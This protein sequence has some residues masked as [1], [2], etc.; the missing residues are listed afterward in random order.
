MAV[1][2][3]A[4]LSGMT[5]CTSD[6]NGQA[7]AGREQAAPGAPTWTSSADSGDSAA[8]AVE[9]P[10]DAPNAG[11]SPSDSPVAAPGPAERWQATAAPAVP[12]SALEAY[13]FEAGPVQFDLPAELD[14]V[15]GLA[16]DGEGRMF[17]HQDERAIIFEI[18][19]RTGAQVRAFQLGR[20]GIRGDFEGIAIAGEQM[21]LLSSEG[22]LYSLATPAPGAEG[23]YARVR[24]DTQRWCQEFE[25]LDF[26][27][28][29]VE[30]LLACKTTRGREL[31][32]RLIVF[33]YSLSTS[34]LVETPRLNLSLDVLTRAGLDARLSPSGIA[35]HPVTGT[36]F[37][38]AA[39]ENLIVELTRT[40]ELMGTAR[41]R[42]RVHRQPEGIAFAADGTL[43]IADEAPSGRAKLSVYTPDVARLRPANE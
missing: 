33:A 21:Y 13:D 14:E 25:G 41:L 43:Y 26:D 5:G 2:A 42:S 27:P 24:L 1:A 36:L 19:P 15:S 16:I 38:I 31:R 4:S 34:A 18:D 9:D 10:N 17:A 23:E 12:F 3:V 20:N 7:T 35:I 30:L 40:G 22:T 6:G 8:G 37:V 32:D 11:T 39:I 29:A 28:Q